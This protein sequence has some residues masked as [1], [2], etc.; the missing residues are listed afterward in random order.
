MVPDMDTFELGPLYRKK[1]SDEAGKLHRAAG[2]RGLTRESVRNSDVSAYI[3]TFNARERGT[4]L[5]ATRAMA[6]D[7]ACAERVGAMP[8]KRA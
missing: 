1:S 8:R 7:P 4:I 5:A 3:V 6:H 2:V